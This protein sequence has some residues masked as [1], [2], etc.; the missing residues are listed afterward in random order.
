MAKID[1]CPI[2]GKRKK[3]TREI[4]RYSAGGQHIQKPICVSCSKKI[5]PKWIKKI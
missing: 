5:T 1:V 4:N 2:C 3:L